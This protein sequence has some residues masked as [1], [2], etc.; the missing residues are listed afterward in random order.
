MAATA[1]EAGLTLLHHDRDFE[2][3]ARTTG[4][5]VRMLDL[6]QPPTPTA[7]L[8]VSAPLMPISSSA[9]ASI[10]VAVG[11]R[12]ELTHAGSCPQEEPVVLRQRQAK[13]AFRPL[14]L[15]IDRSHEALLWACR[16]VERLWLQT[17]QVG[18]L[19]IE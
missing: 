2:P 5:P 11:R 14:Y 4:Q 10:E 3:I 1:E 17:K 8:L 7:E 19:L 9:E 6:K 15:S 12:H 13:V 16:S 18:H